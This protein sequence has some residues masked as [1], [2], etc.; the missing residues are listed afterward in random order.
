VA[1]F[2]YCLNTSTIRPASLPEKIQAAGEAGYSAIEL[3]HDDVDPYLAQGGK[4][5]DVRKMLADWALTV[6]SMIYLGGWFE[7]TGEEH[8]KNVEECRRRLHQAAELG[9][10]ICV[11]GPPA[12]QADLELG[13][14]H[15]RELLEIGK[16]VGVR[17]AV[18]FLGF[19]DEFN[20]IASCVQVARGTGDPTACIVID[21]F[22][23]FRGG[24]GIEA[25]AG[26]GLKPHEIGILHFNDAPTSP[27]RE[28]QHD[29][30]RVLPGDGHLDLRRY[31][32]IA[33]EIGYKGA[34]SL[35]LFNEELW[36]LSPLEVAKL[37]LS[38]MRAVVEG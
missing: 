28:R 6:P 24:D 34:L 4:L 19:V 37:G 21:P 8:R 26:Q 14:A 35:E 2:I 23:L 17:P 30:D 18:E 12:G 31:V 9:A 29:P 33:R 36:R 5:A 15:Y 25:M 1:D 7:T 20:R 27:P 11:A 10:G 38:K 3:W 32:Q 16:S 13:T 22:H